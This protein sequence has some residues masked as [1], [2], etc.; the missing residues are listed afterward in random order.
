M[1]I[2]DS[3]YY[4]NIN[5]Q[6]AKRVK[7]TFGPFQKEKEEREKREKG[8]RYIGLFPSQPKI[9]SARGDGKVEKMAMRLAFIISVTFLANIF[10][11]I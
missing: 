6:Q 9:A 8:Y 11:P 2:R 3:Y 5:V 10:Q 1:C 4:L 7:H